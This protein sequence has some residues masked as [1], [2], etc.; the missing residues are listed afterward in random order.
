MNNLITKTKLIFL[1]IC[2]SSFSLSAA[3]VVVNGSGLTGTYTT[4]SAGINAANP[5]DRILVSNQSFP[6]QE[7]TIFIDKDV[8]ILPYNDIVHILFDGHIEITLDSI[9]SLTLIGFDSYN[10]NIHTVFNDTSRNSLTNINIIDSRFNRVFCSQTKTSIYFSFSTLNY[11]YMTHG[12]VIGCNINRMLF[13][14]FDYSTISTTSNPPIDQFFDFY[15]QTSKLGA[16]GYPSGCELF[17]NYIPFGNVNTYS[18]TCNIIGNSI[19]HIVILNKDF[20]LDVRNNVI[21]YYGFAI[22]LLCPPSVGFNQIIN[23]S[24]SSSSTDHTLNFY[25]GYCNS[26][27]LY[28]FQD[29]SIR[30]LNNNYDGY[31]ARLN[32]PNSSN[33]TNFISSLSNINIVKNSISSYN[34]NSNIY[35]DLDV[36]ALQN[37]NIGPNNYSNNNPN[38]SAEF[39]NLDLSLNVL[40]KDGGSYAFDNINPT[41]N[42][43]FGSFSGSKSRITYLNLPTQMF[44]PSNIKIKAKAVHGN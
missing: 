23:N 24:F 40:G 35:G 3:D 32:S 18:D 16:S 19:D 29:I 6:Y 31:Y 42:I 39:L 41:G 17:S 12:D 37:F 15:G 27:N 25:A 9:S 10:T 34:N 44:D 7:D 8:T 11:I 43:G 22:L 14:N 30:L 38:P 13:G 4:I 36:L 33:S 20:A 1:M 2:I 28:N 26:T 21:G 5:G